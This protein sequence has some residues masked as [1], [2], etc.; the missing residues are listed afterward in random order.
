MVQAPEEARSYI[1][2]DN[3]PYDNDLRLIIVDEDAKSEDF[4]TV[5]E[6]E[7]DEFLAEEKKSDEDDEDDSSSDDSLSDASLEPPPEKPKKIISRAIPSLYAAKVK[8]PL[9]ESLNPENQLEKPESPKLVTQVG[10]FAH[11]ATFPASCQPYLAVHDPCH[12]I[13]ESPSR[14]YILTHLQHW[15]ILSDPSSAEEELEKAETSLNDPKAVKERNL[16]RRQKDNSRRREAEEKEKQN[17]DLQMKP[18]AENSA[19]IKAAPLSRLQHGGTS[20]SNGAQTETS[21]KPR[22]IRA[23]IHETKGAVQKNK[24]KASKSYSAMTQSS[25]L[26]R[27]CM[28]HFWE[29]AVAM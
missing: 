28:W 14:Y 13:R 16:A 12:L 25:P 4:Q 20:I 18:Q 22:Q 27:P 2:T 29:A 19:P 15:I 6:D 17:R 26:Q 10:N 7:E 9:A 1:R 8:A 23:S 21:K 24:V 5:E 11:D 3:Q